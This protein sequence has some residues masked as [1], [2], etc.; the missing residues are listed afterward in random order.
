MIILLLGLVL[1]FS[2][3]S[4]TI[5]APRWREKKRQRW[6]RSAWRWI[7]SLGSIIAVLLIAWGYD[8][9]RLTPVVVYVT[10]GWVRR[11]TDIL[12]LGVFPLVYA[13]F[14]PCR[15]RT[16]LKYPD[17]VAIKLWAVAHLLVNGM[18]ADLFLFGSFL[19]WAVVNRI[20]LRHRVR[21]IPSGV[22]S[23][24]NDLVAV[25]AGL[26]TYLVIIFYLHYKIIG[27][28]PF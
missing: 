20:S 2:L 16:A 23:K 14:L 26:V 27:M 5:V 15:I 4:L 7:Y 28:A 1:F 13:A 6:G 9:T 22:A 25:I 10:P 11:V 12:M 24:Y 8:R 18:L 17:L 3:H 21:I 19:I